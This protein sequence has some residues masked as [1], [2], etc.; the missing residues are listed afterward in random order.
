MDIFD[1]IVLS[2]LYGCEVWVLDRNMKDIM[3]ILEMFVDSM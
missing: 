1:G 2:V 3:N